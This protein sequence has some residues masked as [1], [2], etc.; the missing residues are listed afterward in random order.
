MGIE[1]PK[2]INKL[3]NQLDIDFSGDIT[4]GEFA[5]VFKEL[6]EI[7]PGF[8]RDHLVEKS[9]EWKVVYKNKILIIDDWKYQKMQEAGDE[10]KPGDYLRGN[11]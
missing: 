10:R 3:D 7:D 2:K 8:D 4:E 11:Y 1:M 6:R 5:Q 9:G